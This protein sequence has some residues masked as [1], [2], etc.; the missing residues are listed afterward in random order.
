M[1]NV[2]EEREQTSVETVDT[3][4]IVVQAIPTTTDQ[5]PTTSLVQS[6]LQ[7][8]TDETGDKKKKKKKKAKTGRQKEL[9]RF[10]LC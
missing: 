10:E 9:V 5:P 3:A 7:E 4:P 1:A 8:Q 2:T 6:L